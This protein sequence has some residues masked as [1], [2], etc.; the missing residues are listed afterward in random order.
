MGLMFD[1]RISFED[2]VTR[3][4]VQL[5]VLG[6]LGSLLS[7]LI[8]GPPQPG[9]LLITDR[10]VGQLYGHAAA[11]SLR[12][13]GLKTLEFQIDPGEGSKSLEVVGEVYRYL[14]GHSLARDTMIVSLGGGVVSDLAGF[15]AAT[16]MRGIRFVVCPT[17][18][19]ADVDASI[20]GKTAINVP[21]GKNL[22]GAFH[23][24]ILVAV[25][26]VCL[27]TLNARDVRAGL[28]ES[29][30]HALIFSDE[31][32]TW[33]EANAHAILALDDPTVVEL[34]LRN[35][36]VKAGIVEKDAHERTGL[37]MLLNFGHT[38]GHA[39]EECSRFALRHGECVS[40]GM[41]AACRL[42]HAMGLLDQSVVRRAETTLAR[43]GLPTE[44]RDP[45]DTDL[46]MA[47]IR[48][49]KK[50]RGGTEHFVLLEAIGRPVVRDDI[51][52]QAVR[53]AYESLLP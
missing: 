51:P 4:A 17:T 13:A 29:V 35:L 52:Q 31:F 20:G 30:K 43:F 37:R 47:T 6:K 12:E 10:Y 18:L 32:V 2:Q 34:I 49:D 21:G 22:V 38:I 14:A 50:I 11:Q 23:Q 1:L 27:K 3:I 42:S 19:E 15:V 53:D 36:R 24:P 16:W 44:L 8:V 26:P 33:H 25:D 40:L 45:I 5:D 39:I 41:V 9:V 46:I 7:Q 28:A 48:K